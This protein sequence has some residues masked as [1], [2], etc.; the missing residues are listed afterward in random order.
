MHLSESPKP[1][2]F[3]DTI[4]KHKFGLLIRARVATDRFK[5]TA[6]RPKDHNGP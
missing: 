6:R 5:F 3:H 2:T 4:G 1:R